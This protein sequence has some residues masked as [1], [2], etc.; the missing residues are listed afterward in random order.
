M[1]YSRLQCATLDQSGFSFVREEPAAGC[2]AQCY[3]LLHTGVPPGT[4]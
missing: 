3:T 2:V 1:F 4:S